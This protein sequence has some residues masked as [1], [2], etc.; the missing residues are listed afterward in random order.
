LASELSSGNVAIHAVRLLPSASSYTIGPIVPETIVQTG[1]TLIAANGSALGIVDSLDVFH[2]LNGTG[3]IAF[4]VRMTDA[5]QA[6]V[7]AKRRQIAYRQSDAEPDVPLYFGK[8]SSTRDDCSDSEG[9]AKTLCYGCALCSVATM[10]ATYPG[11]EFFTPA[12]LNQ[13]ILSLPNQ[14]YDGRASMPFEKVPQA[15]GLD[16]VWVDSGT[17]TD[18]DAYL[19]EHFCQGDRIILRLLETITQNGETRTTDSAGSPLTHYIFVTAKGDSDW[20][21]F[22]PG[23]KNAPDTLSA[24]LS[25]FTTYHDS[26]DAFRQFVV[27]EGRAFRRISTAGTLAISGHSPVEILV[28][29]PLGRRLGSGGITNPDVFEIPNGSYFRDTSIAAAEGDGPSDGNPHAV[30]TAY[31]PFPVTGL[32]QVEVTGTGTG[33]FA[34][35]FDATGPG[36]VSRHRS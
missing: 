6:I 25:G 24:H 17:I 32:Y 31:V 20:K 15:V 8:K 27:D 19:D 12:K 3:T 22:D 21:V 7:F 35:V 9:R 33:A 16:G 5:R 36:A 2:S 29:D 1:Q 14:G 11:Y 10:L 18:Y 13:K 26:G 28:S 23:W 34:V 30:K 4:W